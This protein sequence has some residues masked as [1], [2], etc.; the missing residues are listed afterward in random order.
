MAVAGEGYML[1]QTEFELSKKPKFR[2]LNFAYQDNFGAS[3]NFGI[4]QANR[5]SVVIPLYS[6][7]PGTS[8]LLNRLDDEVKHKEKVTFGQ[9]VLTGLGLVVVGAYMYGVVRCVKDA[10]KYD[11]NVTTTEEGRCS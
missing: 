9:V 6:N 5:R 10:F 1:M 7:T 4:G 8:G 2:Q 11:F 3:T